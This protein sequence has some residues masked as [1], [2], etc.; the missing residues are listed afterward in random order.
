MWTGVF[1]GIRASV[2]SGFRTST[3]IELHR[4][5]RARFAL[6]ALTVTCAV[7]FTATPGEV[8]AATP[9]FG[10]RMDFR[11][12]EAPNGVVA[13]DFNQD[14]IPDLIIADHGLTHQGTTASVLLGSGDGTFRKRATIET[15]RG[16]V[17]LSSADLNEDGVPDLIA[18]NE[19]VATFAVDTTTWAIPPISVFLGVG[20]GTFLP[21]VNYGHHPEWR[22]T[23]VLTVADVNEDGHLD[24]LM[25]IVNVWSAAKLTNTTT[26]G[27][28]TVTDPANHFTSSLV[29]T[30]VTSSG[31]PD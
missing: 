16:I 17:S 30:W 13:A 3:P 26:L 9:L 5:W 18:L 28:T 6:W 14:S 7:A 31:A 15:E 23:K 21:R 1:S 29:G 2:Y 20:D 22:E 11:T 25:G 8:S 19:G 27:S 12:G 24:V 10:P 4:I